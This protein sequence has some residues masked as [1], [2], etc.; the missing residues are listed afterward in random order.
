[1]ALA[2][3]VNFGS[4]TTGPLPLEFG[5]THFQFHCEVSQGICGGKD[6]KNL[7][8]WSEIESAGIRE[9]WISLNECLLGNPEGKVRERHG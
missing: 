8:F 6:G 7:G 5:T 3:K 4:L 2:S 9:F 1:M